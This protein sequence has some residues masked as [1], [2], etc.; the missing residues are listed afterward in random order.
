MESADA[1]DFQSSLLHQLLNIPIPNTAP[2]LYMLMQVF[3]E[4]VVE[5][6]IMALAVLEKQN[7]SILAANTFHLPEC[8][9]WDIHTT[10]RKI[11]F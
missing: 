5:P 1:L 4:Y 8:S 6:V 10:Q 9:H 3:I 11:I 2:S 7:L